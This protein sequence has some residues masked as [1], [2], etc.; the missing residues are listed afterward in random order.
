M[1]KVKTKQS[2]KERRAERVKQQQQQQQILLLVVGV[3]L[4]VAVAGVIFFST[5]PVDRVFINSTYDYTPFI[6]KGYMGVTE[7]GYPYLG[8]TDAPTKMEVVE[9]LSCIVCQ[10]FHSSFFN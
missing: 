4:L 9:S 5:R 1:G 7:E 10:Q 2:A 6:D 3:V 8:R